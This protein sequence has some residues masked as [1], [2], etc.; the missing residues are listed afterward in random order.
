MSD[1]TTGPGASGDAGTTPDYAAKYNGLQAAFQK[2]TNEFAAREQ[3]W[4]AERAEHEAK[5]AR[6]AEYEA[7]D[8]AADE[9][10]RARQEFDS[11]S[12]RFAPTPMSHGG[13]SRSIAGQDRDDGSPEAAYGKLAK[14]LG[15]TLG[16]T[17][18]P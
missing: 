14:A 17:S 12:A 3:A 10:R 4:E 9:E 7:R 8:A 6:L 18:W 5:A 16:K 1:Q 2:R 11:L 13:A 15:T